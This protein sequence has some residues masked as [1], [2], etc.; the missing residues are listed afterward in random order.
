MIKD[1]LLRKT[2]GAVQTGLN[3]DDLKTIPIVSF[4]GEFV[5]TISNYYNTSYTLLEYAKKTY[6]IAENKLLTH[7]GLANYTPSTENTAQKSFSESFG[8]SGRLD[9]E[10]YQPKYEEIKQKVIE[11]NCFELSELVQIN[12]SIEPGSEYYSDV[13]IPFYRVSNLTKFGLT[14]PEIKIP[15]DTVKNIE[16]LFPR[17]NTILLS[18]D[19]SVGLAYKVQQDMEAVTSGAI[20]HL[21]I[22]DNDQVLPDYLTLVLNS[23]IVQIQAERDAGGSIIQHWKPSEISKV[24]IPLLSMDIQREIAAKIQESF[25]LRK[26]ADELLEAAKRAVEIAIE[27]DEESAMAYLNAV[28]GE[29]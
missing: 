29:E 26:R 4:S 27:Q 3:L 20:L 11:H 23:M 1:L 8:Q 9:A 7:L 22:K 19:G 6:R 21:T 24:I 16:S 18:K 12:K 2:R 13:G 14:D 15:F 25:A 28:T 5:K 10:Y 17:K